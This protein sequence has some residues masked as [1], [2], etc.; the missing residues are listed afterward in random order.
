V[1]SVPRRRRAGQDKTP[2]DEPTRR[3]WEHV[4]RSPVQWLISAEDLK[5]CA[6]LVGQRFVE[7]FATRIPPGASESTEGVPAVS[8]GPIFQMLAGYSIEALVKG[9]CVAREPDVIVEGE[10]PEWLTTHDLEALLRRANVQLADADQ[11]FL[12]RLHLSVVWS[13]RYPVP[14]SAGQFQKFSSSGDLAAFR[15]LYDILVPVLQEEMRRA[16]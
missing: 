4:A 9:I 6:E 3:Q 5:A 10:L 11:R 1:N 7:Y 16:D 8:F 2:V 13:G 15:R 14:K 12:R